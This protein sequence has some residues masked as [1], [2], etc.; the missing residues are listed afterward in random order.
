VRKAWNRLRLEGVNVGLV[1]LLGDLVDDHDPAWAETGLSELA[2]ALRKFNVPILAVPGNHDGEAG[3]YARILGSPTGRHEVGGYGFLLF[4]DAYGADDSAVRSPDEL[5]LPARA[6]SERPDL[7]WVALQHN[8]LHPDIA[9]DYPYMP[10]NAGAIRA[11]YRESGVVLSLSGH[12]HAGQAEHDVGGTHYATVPALCEAPFQFAHVQLRGRNARVHFHALRMVTPGL[13]DVHCHTEY[14]YCGTNIAAAQVVGIGRCLGVEQI[15]AVEHAFSSTLARRTPGAGG[16]GGRRHG[17]PRLGD[18]PR[19]HAGVSGL[20]AGSA[21]PP[22]EDWARSGSAR[23][24]QPA[25]G[26]RR[27]PRVGPAAGR[28]ACH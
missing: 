21:R 15:C 27:S 3:R 4:H 8:P 26:R 23:R 13:T 7:P 18:R 22:R 16:A 5:A 10:L 2:A 11:G 19:P 17:A 1:V 20:C 12:Y 6:A 25:A 14:A 28:R 24:R 9:E